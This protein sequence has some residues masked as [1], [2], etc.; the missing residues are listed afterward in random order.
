MKY[1][2]V[3]DR[4]VFPPEL[5]KFEGEI[6][7]VGPAGVEFTDEQML[8]LA[9]YDINSRLRFAPGPGDKDVIVFRNP[10][11]DCRAAIAG[12]MVRLLVGRN[13][14]VISPPFFRP[15]R[16]IPQE[17]DRATVEVIEMY[18]RLDAWRWSRYMA[19]TI[20]HGRRVTPRKIDVPEIDW[21]FNHAT[22]RKPTGDIPSLQK[23]AYQSFS[24]AHRTFFQSEHGPMLAYSAQNVHIK[25]AGMI[26]A[27]DQPTH[28]M[29]DKLKTQTHLFPAAI[30]RLV[31]LLE[32][33]QYLGS[34]VW[35]VNDNLTYDAAVTSG[36]ERADER[37]VITRD[38]EK[39]V[40]TANGTKAVNARYVQ[41][42]AR[43]FIASCREGK[44]TD[45]D[46]YHKVVYKQEMH[47]ASGA[48]GSC[49][50]VA[51]KCREFF[52]PHATVIVLE[53]I[54]FLFRQFLNR[55][56]VIRIGMVWFFGGAYKFYLYMNK[57]KGMT[58]D[59]GDFTNIDK[60]IKAILLAL[61][62]NS[63]VMYLDLKN[64]KPEDVRCYRTAL[65][66][67][68]KIRIVKVT[69]MEGNQWV[70]MT[71]VMPSG[72]LDTSDGDSWVVVF[73]ICC[74]IE[75]LRERN[76]NVCRII[77]IYFF[78]QFVLAVYGDD[79]IQGIGPEL[80]AI[81][82]E[83][84]F[85]AYVE[86]YWDMK[87][88]EIRTN[89]P[90]L[91]KIYD[92]YIIQDGAIFLKRYLI[93]RPA[94]MPEKCAPVVAWKPAWHHFVRIPYSTNGKISRSRML[95]SAIGHAWD[96]QGVNLHA[97]QELAYLYNDMILSWD[98]S[99]EGIRRMINAE[100][101]N[102]KVK[103]KMLLK[104]GISRESFYQFPSMAQLFEYHVPSEKADYKVDPM[105]AFNVSE[106]ENLE[107]LDHEI[108]EPH[109]LE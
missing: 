68:A 17:M 88:R 63:G 19:R 10:P 73:L 79:H 71:G 101:E 34:I 100:F 51:M 45:I 103:T 90:L 84:G 37:R 41:K 98:L 35:S 60:T 29:S 99:E 81:L 105:T 3:S 92:D 47:Y 80:R 30:S 9:L 1:E 31:D 55:G 25:K 66:L 5:S 18:Q 89:L 74:W 56:N 40:M 70:V 4:F 27:F 95:C 85:A 16:L 106:F 87:I 54:F 39:I 97:Y 57:C 69:R 102:E 50:K 49:N 93:E 76:S 109:D 96:C 91:A 36:G 32:T 24:Y 2:L 86:E 14:R 20:V 42:K 46:H 107:P 83:H 15:M 53:R 21:T 108:V 94:H 23:L 52:I 75:Y 33:R 59:D 28:T 26:K 64:M 7:R 61:H 6:P 67:L 8:L 62:I 22:T 104:L 77:D 58:Y 78:T 44:V 12:A 38:K 11:I 43:S 13:Q 72:I 65:R 82:N 48:P